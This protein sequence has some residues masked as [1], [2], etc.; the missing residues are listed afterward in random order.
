LRLGRVQKGGYLRLWRV[1]RF[2]VSFKGVSATSTPTR[3]PPHVPHHTVVREIGR[4]SYGEIWLA[5]SLT[6]AWRAVKIVDRA[7]FEDERAFEREFEGMAKFEPVSREHGGFVD[8]L[9]VGRSDDEAFFYYVME[10]ADDLIPR[11]EFEPLIYQPKTLKSE[12]QRVMRLPAQEAI[13]LGLSLTLAMAALH[14]HGLVHRDIKPA[15]IIFVGSQ[16][17]IADIGL[18]SSLGQGSFVGT[19]GYVPPEGPGTAQA[20]IFSLGKVLYELAMG[21]DRMDFPEVNTDIDALPDREL[22]L[23]L[24]HVLWRACAHSTADR[25]V[26][27]DEMHEDLLRVRDGLPLV[28]DGI[29][30]RRWLPIAALLVAA[31]TAFAWW[32]GGAPLS[33]MAG[34]KGTV[35]FQ[36]EPPDARILIPS[37]GRWLA[38]TADGHKDVPAG[39]HEAKA[40][41]K[42]YD[43]QPFTFQVVSGGETR[44]PKIVLQRSKGWAVI[45]STPPGCAFELRDGTN[46]RTGIT[47][48]RFEYP[49]GEYDVVFRHKGHEKSK[50]LVLERGSDC[51]AREEFVARK[52]LVTSNPLGAEIFSAG[53]KLGTAPCEV[54]LL[55]G[56][57]ELVARYAPWKDVPRDIVVGSGEAEAIAFAFPTGT[58]KISTKPGGARVFLG[59]KR[60]GETTDGAYSQG[61]LP[62]GEMIYTLE[63][64]GYKSQQV[65]VTIEPGKQT[66]EP[67]VFEARPGPRNGE[68]WTNSVAMKFVPVGPTGNLLAGV[69]PVRVRDFAV[70]SADTG[71]TRLTVDFPQDDNHPVVR[72][73]W[74][75]A[76]AFCAWLTQHERQI[77]KLD[78][79]QLY[80]LPTDAEWSMLAGIPEE[81]GDTPEKRDGSNRDFL[82]GTKWPPPLNAGNYA[83][84][85]L[86]QGLVPR[87]KGGSIA[88]YNDGFSHTSPVGTFAPN[89]FGLFDV[90]G[91]VWQWVE[92]SYNGGKQKKDWG[93]LRGGCWATA[94]EE[95][96]RLGYRNVVSRDERDV[97]FGFR[98]VLVT[99]F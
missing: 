87:A 49:V 33:V 67:V 83:D 98:C 36:T 57:H 55:E 21:K 7:R 63:L 8:I 5:R 9:H 84:Q 1:A 46:P 10:L 82:W 31:G 54:P 66:W 50:R 44:V 78:E 3:T 85:A 68:P 15:N 27:A 17:K 52:I 58:V 2:S 95:E 70:Y 35:Y 20:D 16:P 18:V 48:D 61:G 88:G 30:R 65:K 81:N 37:M 34:G 41:L 59:N 6:G 56:K 26:S 25:Y 74:E 77:G 72:V 75:D 40:I 24:N 12:L 29:A 45:E 51:L 79:G 53:Q 62:P 94:K 47:P 91:N 80:R 69:W 92:D 28:S 38:A 99:G 86:R 42:D 89:A 11:E 71:R 64:D 93:V 14:R 60:V 73:N 32:R 90:S 97:I 96:L 39:E 23:R 4:G 22:L 43:P 13:G 76:N 19:E